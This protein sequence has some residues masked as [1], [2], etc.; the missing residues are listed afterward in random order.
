MKE[1]NKALQTRKLETNLKKIKQNKI[2][3]SASIK[4][5]SATINYHFLLAFRSKE[6]TTS[7]FLLCDIAFQRQKVRPSNLCMPRV[8]AIP[9]F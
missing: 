4:L 8:N 3:L 9:C 7:F 1:R 2:K 5:Q 6:L